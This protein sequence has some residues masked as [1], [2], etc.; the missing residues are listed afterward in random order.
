MPSRPYCGAGLIL[1]VKDNYTAGQPE[2]KVCLN[3]LRLRPAWLT[4][5]GIGHPRL[6]Y[7]VAGPAAAAAALITPSSTGIGAGSFAFGISLPISL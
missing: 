5:C 1:L 3:C 4:K 6:R 7:F 2:F